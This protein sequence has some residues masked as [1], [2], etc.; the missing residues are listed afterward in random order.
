MLVGERVGVPQ[1]PPPHTHTAANYNI[2][3]RMILQGSRRGDS[4]LT[5]FTLLRE[6]VELKRSPSS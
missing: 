4:S 1:E 2:W 5:Q 6:A 3:S